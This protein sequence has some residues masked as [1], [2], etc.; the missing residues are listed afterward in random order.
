M[1]H[2]KAVADDPSVK[3]IATGVTASPLGECGKMHPDINGRQDS[4][5]HTF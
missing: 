5:R 3:N 1:L 2:R 4:G